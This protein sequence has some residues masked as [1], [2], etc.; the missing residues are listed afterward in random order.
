MIHAEVLEDGLHVT[1]VEEA[2]EIADT[3]NKI[4]ISK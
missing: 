3:W 2:L 4:Q 1:E